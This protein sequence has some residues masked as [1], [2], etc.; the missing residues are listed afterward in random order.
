ML[1]QIEKLNPCHSFTNQ[2]CFPHEFVMYGERY[3]EWLN[4]EKDVDERDTSK[5]NCTCHHCHYQSNADAKEEDNLEEHPIPYKNCTLRAEIPKYDTVGDTE[6]STDPG[7]SYTP[8]MIEIL[9][10]HDIHVCFNTLDIKGNP[11]LLE[12]EPKDFM[13][14]H[15]FSSSKKHC[16]CNTCMRKMNWAYD[17]EIPEAPADYRW[18]FVGDRLSFDEHFEFTPA[19]LNTV[20]WSTLFNDNEELFEYKDGFAPDAGV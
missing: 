19:T 13:D 2:N 11:K 3:H 9:H 14:K 10:E 1:N 4:D 8:E 17:C 5:I 6:P 16:V 20:G 7:A 12:C 15:E 18:P